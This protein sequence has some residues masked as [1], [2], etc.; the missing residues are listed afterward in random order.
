MKFAGVALEDAIERFGQTA[1]DPQFAMVAQLPAFVA[2]QM[3][4]T[5][6][7]L[8]LDKPSN[9]GGGVEELPLPP[10]V[11]PGAE[12]PLLPAPSH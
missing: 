5:E 6:L 1:A 2:T 9:T 12:G 10:P 8:R 4:L 3:V 7:R 11:Q